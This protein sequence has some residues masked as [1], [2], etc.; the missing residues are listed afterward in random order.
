MDRPVAPGLEGFLC[1]RA[2]DT[3]APRLAPAVSA[4]GR[5]APGAAA[6]APLRGL[7]HW[8]QWVLLGGWIGSWGF[9]GL[10]VAPM[11]FRLLPGEASA[12]LAGPLLR[13]LHLYGLAAGLAV[14]LLGWLLRTGRASVLGALGLAGLCALAEFGV[15]AAIADVRPSEMGAGATAS[16]AARFAWLHQVSQALFAGVWLGTLGLAALLVRSGPGRRGNSPKSPEI[17]PIS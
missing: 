15:R 1:V 11:A 4:P 14:A 7:G 6:S 8:L 3:A 5:R 12:Q 13:H 9:F 2:S 16:E 17:G 10:A